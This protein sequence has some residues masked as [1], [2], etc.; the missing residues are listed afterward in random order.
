M[1]DVRVDLVLDRAVDRSRVLVH[2]RLQLREVGFHTDPSPVRRSPW[3]VPSEGGRRLPRASLPGSGARVTSSVT[4]VVVFR[5]RQA[6][7]R[8]RSAVRARLS[9]AARARRSD[10]SRPPRSGSGP[11]TSS[12]SRA[13]GSRTGTSRGRRHRSARAIAPA[14]RPRR[15][16]RGRVAF[17]IETSTIV[18]PLRPRGQTASRLVGSSARRAGR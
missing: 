6:L 1:V 10:R 18:Q 4:I 17:G 3:P 12:S 5:R 15:P 16:R 8:A 14:A 13:G 11:R 7:L 2:A 9:T